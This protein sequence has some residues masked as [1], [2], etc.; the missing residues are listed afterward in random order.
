ML[1]ALL[2]ALAYVVRTATAAGLI[3]IVDTFAIAP[4]AYLKFVVATAAT[5]L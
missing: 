5:K 1:S 2:F 4:P 3:T